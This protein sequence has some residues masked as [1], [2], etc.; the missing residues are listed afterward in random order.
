MKTWIPVT[1]KGGLEGVL[2]RTESLTVSVN[3]YHNFIF[4][5]FIFWTEGFINQQS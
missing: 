5:F 1:A 2:T 3:D 4:F